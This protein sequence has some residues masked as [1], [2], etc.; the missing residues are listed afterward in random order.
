MRNKPVAAPP[1]AAASQPELIQGVQEQ[2]GTDEQRAALAWSSFN[3]AVVNA[4]FV[5]YV[6]PNL[7][8]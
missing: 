8:L 6:G 5:L 1:E 2:K 4:G 7:P 3:S